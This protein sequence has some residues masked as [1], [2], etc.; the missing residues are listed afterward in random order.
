M[1]KKFGHTKAQ[2]WYNVDKE[3]NV[4]EETKE[5][6]EEGCLFMV[7]KNFTGETDTTWLID[8]GCSNHMSGNKDLFHSLEDV[9]H[10]T[11]RLGDG[12]VLDVAGV[13]SVSLH[14]NSGKHNLLHNV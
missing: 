11:V 3:V 12:K 8:S 9:A 4:V 5:E 14:S 6:E 1:C 10:Q 2:C 7:T 13:G